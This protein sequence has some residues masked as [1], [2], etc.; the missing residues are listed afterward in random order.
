MHNPRTNERGANRQETKIFYA[1]FSPPPCGE[2][3]GVGVCESVP[4]GYPLPNP[5]PQG[6]AIA[7]DQLQ[8]MVVASHKLSA[9]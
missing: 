5:P 2:G 3:S 9:G 1:V 7:Y 4:R 6:R 8:P